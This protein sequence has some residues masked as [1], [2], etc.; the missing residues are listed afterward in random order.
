MAKKIQKRSWGLSE[1]TESL[2]WY[3]HGVPQ[4]CLCWAH[5][6]RVIRR[7]YKQSQC[8]SSGVSPSFTPFFQ[9]P[10]FPRLLEGREQVLEEGVALQ[11]CPVSSPWA[12]RGFYSS[13]EGFHQLWLHP[14][15]RLWI[16]K[17]GCRSHCTGQAGNPAGSPVSTGDALEASR[18]VL[19]HLN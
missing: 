6:C 2:S 8:S 14:C 15:P 1:I 9:N 4:L 18:H 16:P 11:C 19:G 13:H 7:P 10:C 12:A 5:P 3:G 17:P